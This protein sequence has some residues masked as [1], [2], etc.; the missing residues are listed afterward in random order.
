MPR[1][2]IDVLRRHLLARHDQVA[3]SFLALLGNHEDH[4][5]G[6]NAAEDFFQRLGR[7][8][9]TFPD[10]GFYHRLPKVTSAPCRLPP[11]RERRTRKTSA[12]IS[13]S[14]PNARTS[15]ALNFMALRTLALPNPSSTGVPAPSSIGA[16]KNAIRSTT[17]AASAAPARCAP[18]SIS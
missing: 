12:S 11:G 13:R 10:L 6:T 14:R 15:S 7:I 2:E 4:A 3:L 17:P 18:P 5:R 9:H 8:D 1:H 16:A